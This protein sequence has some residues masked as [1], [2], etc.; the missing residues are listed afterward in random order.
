MPALAGMVCTLPPGHC[1]AMKS[2]LASLLAA[3][4]VACHASVLTAGDASSATGTWIQL[5]PAG[6]FM[7]RDG[8][9]PWVAGDQA[10]MTA[11]VER[12]RQYHGATDIVVDYDHQSV[13]G[14]KDG[15]GATA[16]AAGW[17]KELQVRGDG[18]WGR[19]EWTASAAAAIKAGEYRY[20]S[21]VIPHRKA[22]GQII[23][24]LNAALTNSPALELATV[25][26]SAL[27]PKETDEGNDMDKILTALG[28]P[29]GSDETAVLSAI[30]ALLTSSTAMARAAGLTD[31]AKPGEVQAAVL[32]ALA[33]RSKIAVAAGLTDKAKGDEIVTAVASAV[34]GGKVDPAKFVPIEQVSALQS[35]IKAL[36]DSITG[37][38]AEIAVATAIKDGKLMPS[39]KE[40]GLDLFKSNQ[41]A[42]D[43][44]VAASPVLTAPQLR[45]PRKGAGDGVALTDAQLA[46][47]TAMGLDPKK[48]AETVKANQA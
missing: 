16:K 13:F 17:I 7:A 47:C 33:D 4:I 27:F 37:E 2:A 18:I 34:S 46:V 11:I 9:G 29:A 25:A 12:T 26:A 32:S 8:R 44:F 14:V 39:M 48:Y 38:K 41:E 30:H 3:S 28:L 1:P 5:M 42:F 35:D 10:A 45:E 19:V 22:D 40:W 23:L 15:V 20:L 36:R 24:I 6:S 43:A 31:K 21:P